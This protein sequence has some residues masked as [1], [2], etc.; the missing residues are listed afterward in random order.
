MEV[1]VVVGCPFIQPVAELFEV[2]GDAL[3]LGIPVLDNHHLG[4]EAFKVKPLDGIQFPSSKVHGHHVDMCQCWDLITDDCVECPLEDVLDFGC[5]N[6]TI[7]PKY[8]LVPLGD[9]DG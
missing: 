7:P 1:I 3:V 6:G 2:V 4:W 8:F 5:V 9:L